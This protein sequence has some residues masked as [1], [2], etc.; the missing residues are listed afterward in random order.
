LI[1]NAEHAMTEMVARAKEQS[2]G[3]SGQRASYQKHLE[4]TTKAEDSMVIATVR[5]NGCGIPP[6]ARG[7]I[8]E[9]FFTTKSAGEG[10]GLGLSISH[11]I[12]SS[13]EG[14]ITFESEINQGTTFILRFPLA[15]EGQ[16]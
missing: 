7:N 6:E 5:D 15:E 11:E 2:E 8:F 3:N 14:D 16:N 4:I 9:P 10:T 1:S 12:I 13:Y